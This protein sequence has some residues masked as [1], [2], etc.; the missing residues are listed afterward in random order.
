MKNLFTRQN[1]VYEIRL[2]STAPLLPKN[3]HSK[4][5]N[6]VLGSLRTS[7]CKLV[8]GPPVL[9][10][11]LR[12]LFGSEQGSRQVVAGHFLYFWSNLRFEGWIITTKIESEG[13]F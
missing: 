11:E 13:L 5:N 2:N 12:N 7:L 4:R 10:T 1:F 8:G 6:P 3:T 9:V